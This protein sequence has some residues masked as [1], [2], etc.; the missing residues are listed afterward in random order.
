MENNENSPY[1]APEA[2]LTAT[3]ETNA[4]FAYT[5]PKNVGAG[6]GLEWIS[7]GFSLFKQ[8]VGMWIVTMIVGFLIML[9]FNFIPLVGPIASMFLTYVWLGGLMLGCQAASEGKPFDVKYLF[10]GFTYKFGSLVLLSVI[11]AVVSVVIMLL[12]MGSTYFSLLTSSGDPSGMPEIGTGFFLSFLIAIALMLPLVM[13]AWFAP[14][15]IVLQNMPVVTAMKESFS[16]CLKNMIP[17]LIYGIIMFV[18]Y[19]LGAIPLL[20]GLLVVVPLV[21]TSMFA[22]YR[23]I[24]LNQD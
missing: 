21:F 5:G 16:G 1:Q 17:F 7:K 15:L 14:A 2:D 22:S 19:I 3:T 6:A 4:L 9:V 24:Y 12:T 11:V 20:L 18:L 23:D 8:D 10:A 13:A